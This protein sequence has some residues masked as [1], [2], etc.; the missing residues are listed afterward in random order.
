MFSH[1]IRGYKIIISG[2]VFYCIK[3]NF[4]HQIRG[5]KIIIAFGH[6][7]SLSITNE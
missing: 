7:Q 2:V 5:Y 3:V 1:E 4:S 6:M